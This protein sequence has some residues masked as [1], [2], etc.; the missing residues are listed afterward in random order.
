MVCTFTSGFNTETTSDH[1]VV[2]VIEMAL[3]GEECVHL[4][5]EVSTTFFPF[6]SQDTA[7]N[8]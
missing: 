6:S 4:N 7:V 1:I 5:E 2:A 3:I 8:M